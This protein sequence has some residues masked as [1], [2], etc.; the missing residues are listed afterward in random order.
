MEEVFTDNFRS[1]VFIHKRV[2]MKVKKKYLS[3]LKNSV[4]QKLIYGRPQMLEQN[5]NT[6]LSYGS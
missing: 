4:K 2:Q 3:G 1:I 5:E 6:L